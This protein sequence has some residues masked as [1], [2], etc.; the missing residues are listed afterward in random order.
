MKKNKKENL[1]F[2]MT[3]KGQGL[4]FDQNEVD[5]NEVKFE[6]II[7]TKK[8]DSL[9]FAEGFE[10]ENEVLFVTTKGFGARFLLSDIR[11]MRVGG[12]G[13]KCVKLSLKTGIV[14]TVIL[15]N[16]KKSKKISMIGMKSLKTV[17]MH[18]IIYFN[19]TINTISLLKM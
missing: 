3:E 15:I 10:K 5:Q 9:L 7:R 16:P 12:Q 4:K 13:V 1:A 2:A 8:G 11:V 19:G 14:S 17:Y 6:K 18:P